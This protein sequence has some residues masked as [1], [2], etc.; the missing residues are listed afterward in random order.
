MGGPLASPVPAL[1]R[2]DSVLRTARR[3][4][5]IAGS[6][7]CLPPGASF[8]A[9]AVGVR[10]LL[11]GALPL[12]AFLLALSSL[13][14]RSHEAHQSASQ[15]SQLYLHTPSGI[16]RPHAPSHF[17][18]SLLGVPLRANVRV[19]PAAHVGEGGPSRSPV[20][21]PVQGMQMSTSQFVPQQLSRSSPLGM[22]LW[23]GPLH[24][25]GTAVSAPFDR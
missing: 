23:H 25:M 2:G 18:L 14:V 5:A 1:G 9:G 19:W 13:L 12:R 17:S 21:S 10:S 20:S 3:A 15:V 24:R 11:P 7:A 16:R 22:S 4:R 8:S 6:P